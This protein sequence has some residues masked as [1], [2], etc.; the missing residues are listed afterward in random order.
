VKEYSLNIY[1]RLPKDV[2]KFPAKNQ[3]LIKNTLRIVCFPLVLLTLV[4]SQF[5]SISSEDS[6]NVHEPES[7]PWEI[8]MANIECISLGIHKYAGAHKGAF[9]SSLRGLYPEYVATL[10]NF[11]HP[12]SP[13]EIHVEEDILPKT[14]YEYIVGRGKFNAPDIIIL[15]EKY[16]SRPGGKYVLFGDGHVEWKSKD[17]LSIL[18]SNQT[19]L[20]LMGL[21][22]SPDAAMFEDIKTGEIYFLSKGKPFKDYFVTSLTRHSVT[23]KRGSDSKKCELKLK[24]GALLRFTEGTTV[25]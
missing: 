10:E 13:D 25:K 19:S 22:G 3:N 20:V 7:S 17:E 2:K 9:P 1:K 14:G 5:Q 12:A 18:L 23:I 21:T 11:E 4:I 24:S 6:T 15:H 16:E 8:S